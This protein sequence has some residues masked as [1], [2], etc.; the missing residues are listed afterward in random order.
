[1]SVRSGEPWRQD[2]ILPWSDGTD[3]GRG[4]LSG[5]PVTAA[6]P[7]P[8]TVAAIVHRHQD[9]LRT[10]LRWLRAPADAVD[11]LVQDTFVAVLSH[12]FEERS[13]AATCAFLRTIAR[14]LLQR[15]FRDA[16]RRNALELD[17][18]AAA[19]ERWLGAD[20]GEAFRAALR[21]CL[22]TLNERQGEAVRLRYGEGRAVAAIGAQLG[23]GVAGAES[24][25]RR[26]RQLLRA[27]IERRLLP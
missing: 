10:Y 13:A 6:H 21:G 18:A 11:D 9:G 8:E 7:G 20:D 27:C 17:E 22:G 4:F 5:V 14:R 15:R 12:P 16:G 24:M 26:L 1:M 25:L 23:I 2:G 3:A 19:W